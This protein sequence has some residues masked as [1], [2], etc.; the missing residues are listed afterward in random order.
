MKKRM[1]RWLGIGLAAVAAL[2]GA[3]CAGAGELAE[4]IRQQE[5]GKAD[6]SGTAPE[7]ENITAVEIGSLRLT[8]IY[9][10]DGVQRE[11]VPVTYQDLNWVIDVG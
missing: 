6:S 4:Q 9:L 1:V 3:G 5:S 8:R 10:D 2:S 7:E 11:D